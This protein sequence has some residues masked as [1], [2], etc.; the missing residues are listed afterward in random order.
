MRR[1]V[2]DGS[3]VEVERVLVLLLLLGLVVVVGSVGVTGRAAL[4]SPRGGRV[5]G[6]DS[7]ASGKVGGAL[8]V[9][10]FVTLPVA[11][12]FGLRGGGAAVLAITP[13]LACALAGGFWLHSTRHR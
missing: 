11:F 1:R 9:F 13:S 12:G 10:G 2:H 7:G 6:R 4:G 8:L 3:V 5:S